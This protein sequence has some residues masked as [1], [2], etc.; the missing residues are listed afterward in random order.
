MKYSTSAKRSFMG[1][2]LPLIKD[3]AADAKPKNGDEGS[4]PDHQG[5]Q[6]TDNSPSEQK[7]YQASS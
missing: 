3:E 4:D 6:K 1:I 2:L 7:R 5:E